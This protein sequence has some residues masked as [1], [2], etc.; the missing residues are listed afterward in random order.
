MSHESRTTRLIFGGIAIFYTVL[1]LVVLNDD[2][3]YS[4]DIG[5]K[6]VQ[7]RALAAQRFTSLDIPY[8]G[9]FLDPD[10]R[11]VPMRPPFFMSVGSQTHAIYPTPPAVVQAL[12]VTTAGLRGMIVV[13][14]FAALIT[15]YLTARMAERPLRTFVVLGLGLAS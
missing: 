10:R 5:I 12:A 3:V 1:G 14:I 8:P 15:L 9:G 11:F 6:F 7:A 4:G 13:T 2:A